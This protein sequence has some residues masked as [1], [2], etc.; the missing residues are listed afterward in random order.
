VKGRRFKPTQRAIC[1]SGLFTENESGAVVGRKRVRYKEV[2]QTPR[3]GGPA[4]LHRP[5]NASNAVLLVL[6]A[7]EAVVRFFCGT[8]ASSSTSRLTS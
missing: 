8:A 5:F 7:Y 2:K 1:R 6:P 3:T 4:P